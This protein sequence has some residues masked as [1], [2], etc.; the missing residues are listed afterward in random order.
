VTAALQDSK[1]ALEALQKKDYFS[2]STKSEV[3]MCVSVSVC[4]CIIYI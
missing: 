4:V 1:Q 2:L 3:Y